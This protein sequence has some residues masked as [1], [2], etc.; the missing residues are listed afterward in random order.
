M[1][2]PKV[3]LEHVNAAIKKE[4]YTVLPDG[5]TTICQLTL[6]NGFTVEGASVCVSIA[7]FNKEL[8]EKYSKEKAIDKAWAFLGF[9]LADR[10]N[11][12]GRDWVQRLIRERD[13]LRVRTDKLAKF[14]VLP[15][16]EGM[17][18]EDR[19][20]LDE[21]LKTMVKYLALLDRRIARLES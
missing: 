20:L 11:D 19:I 12:E 7:N 8:G 13:D 18:E 14:T 9:R 5:R 17:L 10:L 15:T 21:Q 3:S 2:A 4:T 16:F 6:D 1:T